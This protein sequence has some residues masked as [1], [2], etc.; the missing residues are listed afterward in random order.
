MNLVGWFFILLINISQHINLY[1]LYMTKLNIFLKGLF[2]DFTLGVHGTVSPLR[3]TVCLLHFSFFSFDPYDLEYATIDFIVSRI[4]P[5]TPLL[6]LLD[7][8]GPIRDTIKSTVTA[9]R[10]NKWKTLKVNLILELEKTIPWTPCK[11]VEQAL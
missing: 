8:F 9:K 6:L 7:H 5:I 3:N 2:T 10:W 4:G 11:I 1:F